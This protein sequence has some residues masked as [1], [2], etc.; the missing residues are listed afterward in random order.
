[1]RPATRTGQ[2]SDP[3]R[4][5]VKA[6]IA[7][8]M[9]A[10]LVACGEEPPSSAPPLAPVVVVTARRADVPVF[11]EYV[12]RTAPDLVVEIRARVEGLLEEA[13]FAEGREVAK[14]QV[15]FR[16]ERTRYEAEVEKA[17]AA[18]ANAETEHD[19]AV[20]QVSLL[21]AKADLAQGQAA[22]VKARRDTERVRPLAEVRALSAQ[23]LDAA[24]A[25]EDSAAALVEA[26]KATV[27]NTEISTD[28]A[29]RRAQAAIRGAKAAVTDA[30]LLLSYTT[31]V[32][33][34]DGLIGRRLVDV[35]SL[36]GKG[37]ATHLATVSALDPM[38]VTFG[39]PE[40]TYLEVTR[41]GGSGGGRKIASAMT[42]E[43]VLADG[44]K[45]A[46]T[47]SY[48]FAERTLD[49][50]TGTLPLVVAFP[51]P[52][53]LLRPELFGRVRVQLDE[54]KDA[55]VIPQRALQM[56]QGTRIVYVVG[57]GDLVSARTVTLAERVGRDVVVTSGLDGGE[58]VIVEG[59][60]RARPGS[61]VATSH[62]APAVASAGSVR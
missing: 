41:R 7:V 34:I 21:R 59:H 39:V 20:Q 45:Y 60:Q 47:G 27:R 49:V 2:P 19:I 30:E 18:L 56:L 43:L 29:I 46:H 15:L 62:E 51:N 40:E 1:M 25:A 24:V 52:E 44:A 58:R 55:V 28:G 31:I 38:R 61:R 9:V 32:S 23:E 50:A 36:V 14:G 42:Y 16:I 6:A 54:R 12:G 13:A 35:G 5:F 8:S 22:L 37:E 4:A 53:R 33:P 11:A 3:L 26:L 48:L 10:F 57:T 17:R